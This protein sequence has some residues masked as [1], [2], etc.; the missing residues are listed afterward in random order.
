[1]SDPDVEQL[2][3]AIVAILRPHIEQSDE[4][5]RAVAAI[6]EK[7]YEEA[8]RTASIGV[9]EPISPE[10]SGSPTAPT[11][12]GEMRPEEG[13]PSDVRSAAPDR[14]ASAYVP[15]KIGDAVINIPASGT[16]EELTRAR[17]AALDSEAADDPPRD[18]QRWDV[19]LGL[20]EQRC[21]LKSDSCRLLLKRRAGGD[22]PEVEVQTRHQLNEMISR[23]KAMPNCFLWM[24]WRDREQPT[25]AVVSTIADAYDVHADA[26]ALMK[27]V[28]ATP[29]GASQDDQSEAFHLLAEANSALR[30]AI[31]DTWLTDDDRDQAEVHV[32]LRQET[33]D[34][35]VF[36]ERYM[37]ADDIADP[38]KSADLRR[39]IQALRTRVSQRIEATRRIK[40]ALGR[41]RYHSGRLAERGDE[42]EAAQHWS[43]IASGI[44]ELSELGVGA[45]DRRLAEALGAAPASSCPADIL[46]DPTVA[47]VIERVKAVPARSADGS[48]GRAPKREWSDGVLEVRG[49]LKGTRMVLVGGE[50]NLLASQRLTEAFGL[51]DV[52]W[53]SLT[54][55]GSGAPMRAPI[56][57][58][59]TSLV[60]VILKLAG[61]LHT[62]E[63]K[64]FARA[65]GKPCVLLTGGYNPER[66]ARD[67]L[68]QASDRLADPTV[69]T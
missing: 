31:A 10:E 39:R 66:V 50:P 62:D 32:W 29:G 58:P 49:L 24:F 5:R 52:E 44:V 37:T 21:R 8:T 65:A 47:R 25:D 57:S 15:L 22:D 38:A 23:A 48:E 67:I 40:N 41:V 53:V 26:V 55:H 17:Q 6:G 12:P 28:D 2:A 30:R 11:S 51:E 68:D 19:D 64:E 61:H 18:V 20:A 9:V 54:E 14:Q 36:I 43:R 3:S 46:E 63:A 34:R 60:A 1:M 69:G 42:V 56:E 59:Q 13:E 27:H 35:R 33:S 4:L 16:P 45:G 7:L